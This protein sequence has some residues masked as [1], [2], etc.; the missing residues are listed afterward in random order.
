MAGPVCVAGCRRGLAVR[1]GLLLAVGLWACLGPCD[2][3][4]SQT[5]RFP[6]NGYYGAFGDFYDGDYDAALKQFSAQGRM[7][8]RTA[9]S[10]WID[11]ICY[12]TMIGECYYEMGHLSEALE[13]YTF[14]VQLASPFPTGC[15]AC[16][17]RRFGRRGPRCGGRP[18]P[19]ARARGGRAGRLPA[20]R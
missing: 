9:Q 13:H 15:S 14:A 16:S 10:R 18:S 12:E 7:G 19:G 3:A 5:G 17:F 6:S 11:S 1:G 4:W 2:R 20:V 8:I